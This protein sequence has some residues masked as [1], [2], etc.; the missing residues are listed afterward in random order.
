MFSQMKLSLDDHRLITAS[1]DG[2]LCFWEVQDAEGDKPS[3]LDDSFGYANE[4]LVKY[5]S[6]NLAKSSSM[7]NGRS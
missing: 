2:S 6:F 4:I 5:R 1:K 3:T 7:T